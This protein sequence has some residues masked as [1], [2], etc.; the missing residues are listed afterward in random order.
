MRYWRAHGAF[1]LLEDGVM[2]RVRHFI[3][4]GLEEELEAALGRGRD[5]RLGEGG[6]GRP[7]R[8]DRT[9]QKD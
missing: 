2:K 8:R 3:E 1:K 6:E 5:E 7:S 9:R 4:T